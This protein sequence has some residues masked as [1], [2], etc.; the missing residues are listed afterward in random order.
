M[1]E[2]RWLQSQ[3]EKQGRKLD[4]LK[5]ASQPYSKQKTKARKV[6]R[7]ELHLKSEVTRQLASLRLK[8][9]V[10]VRFQLRLFLIYSR[11][12]FVQC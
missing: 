8:Q 10:V 5:S 1:C 3:V 6:D 7:I 11:H 9:T 4:S 12:V 2:P